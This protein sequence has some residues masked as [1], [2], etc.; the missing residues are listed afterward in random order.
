MRLR[1]VGFSVLLVA[2]VAC[3]GGGGGGP[4][5]SPGPTPTPAPTPTPTP[6]PTPPPGRPAANGDTFSYAGS[7]VQGF[8]RFPEPGRPI[9]SPV[10][11]DTQTFT[12]AVTQRVV[13]ATGASYGGATNL[14]DFKT[15]ETD[16][17]VSPAKAL[18]I[19]SDAFASY[20][21]GASGIVRAVATVAQTS[22][23]AKFVTTF[24]PDSGLIDVL[25]EVPGPIVP[26][27]TASLVT[28]ETDPD[29]QT[30]TRTTKADGSY[31]ETSAYP[32]GTTATATEASDGTGTY[33]LPLF[34]APPNSTLSVGAVVPAAGQNPAYIPITIVYAPGLFGANAVTVNRKVPDWYPGTPP[35]PP[36]LAS[37]TYVN[38]GL[39]PF[40][41]SCNVP[42]TVA[43]TGNQLV[44]TGT[45]TDTLFGETETMNTTTYVAAAGVVCTQLADSVT[46]YYDFT[47]Q[48]FRTLATPGTPLQTTT[49]NETLGLTAE[50]L[51]GKVR[52]TNAASSVASS[53]P[54]V[55]AGFLQNFTALVE[56]RRLMRHAAFRQL[57]HPAGAR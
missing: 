30:T 4:C 53:G 36:I 28:A 35:Q 6:T 15:A 40:P 42:A 50:T 48:T 25:P 19:V 32:D 46:K 37:Q 52:A 1:F 41:A 10:Q 27:N 54:R 22:D 51:L 13:V 3:G 49:I 44:Q 18:G 7:L 21:P 45:K 20:P 26:A 33:S 5:C 9:P 11:S 39:Q 38:N 43:T 34:G 16:T 2:L 57:F 8:T 17:Q 47:G 14:T 31:V 29:G 12:S 55:A 24:G 56:R 23:N